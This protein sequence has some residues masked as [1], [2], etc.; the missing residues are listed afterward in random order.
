MKK[1]RIK[2]GKERS[3]LACGG[4]GGGH[5]Q[6]CKDGRAPRSGSFLLN[7]AEWHRQN[8]TTAVAVMVGV[9]GG[10]GGERKDADLDGRTPCTFVFG[11]LDLLSFLFR[12]HHVMAPTKTYRVPPSPLHEPRFHGPARARM[13]GAVWVEEWR[14]QE[15]V[16]YTRTKGLTET[17]TKRLPFFLFF[18]F[19]FFGSES[20]PGVLR[21]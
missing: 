10:D 16:A 12:P 5:K 4:G 14:G 18:F 3:N 6:I 21:F 19:F 8:G 2:I 15:R 20:T 17:S 13:A 9:G 11:F 1:W 7:P